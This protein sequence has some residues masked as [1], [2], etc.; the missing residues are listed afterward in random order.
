MRNPLEF[1]ARF[2]PNNKKSGRP[3]QD[4][5]LS[6]NP[7]VVHLPRRATGERRTRSVL[8]QKRSWLSM[9]NGW[10]F[11]HKGGIKIVATVSLVMILVGLGYWV[12]SWFRV[13]SIVCRS[14]SGICTAE[15]SQDLEGFKDSFIPWSLWVVPEHVVQNFGQVKGVSIATN[16]DRELVLDIETET[17]AVL[18]T[19]TRLEQSGRYFVVSSYGVLM[20]ETNVR[21]EPV[22]YLDNLSA[23]PG[24]YLTLEQLKAI[25]IVYFLSS[26]GYTGTNEQVDHSLHFV[27]SNSVIEVFMPL[28]S[29]VS[30]EEL[31][32]SLHLILRETKMSDNPVQID[33]RF[34][35]P[36][37]RDMT[38]VAPVVEEATSEAA[39]E[40][41]PI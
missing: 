19:T 14:Q 30:A 34:A 37:I 41:E 32:S 22:L 3:R 2:F 36:V 18:V 29:D 26:L 7:G 16:W 5:K 27:L 20:Y 33:M 25:D 24:E 15:I 9:L 11:A 6:G 31:V 8:T 38:Y 28:A 1:I 21:Q 39:I 4:V 13:Q 10:N 40:V 35:K 12:Y 23:L 17:P